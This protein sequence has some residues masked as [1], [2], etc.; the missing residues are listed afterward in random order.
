MIPEEDEMARQTVCSFGDIAHALR[1]RSGE[2]ALDAAERV[3]SDLQ[4]A[5]AMLSDIASLCSAADDETPY[6]A[7]ERLMDDYRDVVRQRDRLV[8]EHGAVEWNAKRVLSVLADI[9]TELEASRFG[10]AALS[11]ARACGALASALRRGR[12]S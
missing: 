10:R 3:Y 9:G 11:A 4:G 2:T 8:A 6:A 5:I 1:S 12:R 7:V